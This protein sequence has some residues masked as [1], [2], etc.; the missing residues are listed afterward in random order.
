MYLLYESFY[1]EII[2]DCG[3]STNIIGL[4]E[5]KEQAL[6]KAQ[7]LIKMDIENNNYVLDVENDNLEENNYVIMFWNNQENWSCYYEIY[8]QKLDLIK[9]QQ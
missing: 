2:Y 3:D 5:T 9:E 6:K 4:Y 1:G 8:I 7:E